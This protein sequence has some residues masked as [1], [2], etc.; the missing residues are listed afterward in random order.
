M[1]ETDVFIADGGPVGLT[2]AVAPGMQGPAVAR[3]EYQSSAAMTAQIAR[4]NDGSVPREACQRI[5]QYT[6]ARWCS[7]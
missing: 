1:T 3:L 7:G 4:T 2:L 6:L 5:S